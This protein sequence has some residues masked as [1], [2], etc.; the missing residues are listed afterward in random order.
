MQTAG[1]SL[2]KSDSLVNT[3]IQR[4]RPRFLL[5]NESFYWTLL[6][7]FY[8]TK[9]FSILKHTGFTMPVY[10]LTHS[11]HLELS[12]IFGAFYCSLALFFLLKYVS[13]LLCLSTRFIM[14]RFTLSRSQLSTELRIPSQKTPQQ[15]NKSL[16]TARCDWALGVKAN[17]HRLAVFLDKLIHQVK[18]N[19]GNRVGCVRSPFRI[20]CTSPSRSCDGPSG[21]G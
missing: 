21:G 19:R 6:A 20:V 12:A 16:Q 14:L 10:S 9:P 13:H 1:L 8:H 17:D 7:F 15:S 3:R 18:D 4:A 5:S 2:P 11:K